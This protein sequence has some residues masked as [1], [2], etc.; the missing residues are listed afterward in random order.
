MTLYEGFMKMPDEEEELG[1]WIISLGLL[2]LFI[3]LPKFVL[4][5]RLFAYGRI[6]DGS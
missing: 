4:Y 5:F 1:L 3:L 6:R 2:L